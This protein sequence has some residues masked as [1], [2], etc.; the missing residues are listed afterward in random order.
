MKYPGRKWRSLRRAVLQQDNGA[1]EY[2]N[3]CPRKM[4]SAD[5][6]D[7]KR[8]RQ[9]GKKWDQIR[10]MK[11]PGRTSTSLRRDVLRQSGEAGENRKPALSKMPP[12]ET[13]DIKRLRLEGKTWEPD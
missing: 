10:D 9:E 12:A 7:I 4:A 2:R 5:M 3:P 11:Y 13:A 8:L 6:A 1:G